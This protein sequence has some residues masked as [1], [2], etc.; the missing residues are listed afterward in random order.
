MFNR[1]C[2]VTRIIISVRHI[3]DLTDLCYEMFVIDGI[4]VTGN[5]RPLG[6]TTVLLWSCRNNSVGRYVVMT[7]VS[8]PITNG[9]ALLINSLSIVIE[10]FACFHHYNS[11]NNIKRKKQRST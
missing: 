4:L 10:L 5:N 8:N 7:R 2:D 1:S 6:K 9:I 3:N 11:N